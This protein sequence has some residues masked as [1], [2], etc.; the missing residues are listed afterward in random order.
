METNK[1]ITGY[2]IDDK[3][4]LLP[5][6]I[7]TFQ[8]ILKFGEMLICPI[9]I[10]RIIG[11]SA[12]DALTIV[13]VSLISAALITVAQAWKRIGPGYLA[14]ANSAVQYFAASIAAA[15]L[16]GIALVSG[17]AVICGAFQIL[18][19]L[20]FRWFRPLLNSSLAGFIVI[21]MALWLGG[22]GVRELFEPNQLGQLMV[23]SD[24]TTA[25]VKQPINLRS[26]ALGF[27]ALFIMLLIRFYSPQ[28]LRAYALLIGIA[29]GWVMS[30]V[31]GWVPNQLANIVDQTPWFAIPH[32]HYFGLAFS[33]QL[34]PAYL[35]AAFI[36]LKTAYG[37]FGSFQKIADPHKPLNLKKIAH[38][39]VITGSGVILSGLLGTYPQNMEPGIA[40]T[41]HALGVYSRKIGFIY[42]GLLIILA[43]IPKFQVSFLTMPA[44][45]NGAA[46]LFLAT[47]LLVVGLFVLDIKKMASWEMHALSLA[48]IIGGSLDV[49]PAFYKSHILGYLEI[50]TPALTVAVITYLVLRFIFSIKHKKQEA[51]L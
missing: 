5:A 40:A 31:L 37:M 35:V 25:I 23:H 1:P 51:T 44:A 46:I 29:F 43:F 2:N 11:A 41:E 38:A 9:L 21:L 18:L 15:K 33:W 19:T 30:F 39:N 45:I 8:F 4:S 12:Q 10:A 13:A 34:L 42:A 3:P 20:L 24:F 36:S 27:I 22:M 48:I 47:M 6:I 26:T 28:R 32:F 7:I 16:G 17:M 14:P 50:T 49:I